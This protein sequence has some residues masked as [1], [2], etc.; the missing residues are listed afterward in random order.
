MVSLIANVNQK[1]ETSYNHLYIVC[2]RVEGTS[3]LA[4]VMKSV[5]VVWLYTYPMLLR[6]LVPLLS[7]L[8]RRGAK[9]VTLT[10]HL[11]EEEASVERVDSKHGL[12]L[13][14]VIKV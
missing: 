6:R 1:L 4:T 14:K 7:W 10:Y 13:Y 9:V 3:E 12:C 2:R 11:T 5:T 8:H